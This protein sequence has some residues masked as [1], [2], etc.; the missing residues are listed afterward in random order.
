[1]LMCDHIICDNALSKGCGL[2]K[3][4]EENLSIS[5]VR[6]LE[7]LGYIENAIA[8]D[9]ETWKLTSKGKKLRK[10]LLGRK[11]LKETVEDWIYIHLLKF[12]VNL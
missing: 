1:M 6:E 7:L 8:P 10:L 9:G 2:L 3:D 11:S 12:N 4:L 5:K